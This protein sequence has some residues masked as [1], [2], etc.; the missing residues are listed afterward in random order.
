MPT[1]LRDGERIGEDV[2]GRPDD[3]DRSPNFLR[4]GTE[5]STLGFNEIEKSDEDTGG[6]GMLRKKRSSVGAGFSLALSY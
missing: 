4:G 2:S 5:N 3:G 6:E 1:L